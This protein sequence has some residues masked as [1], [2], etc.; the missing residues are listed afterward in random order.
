MRQIIFGFC[1]LGLA[2]C[3]GSKDAEDVPADAPKAVNPA[4]QWETPP[5]IGVMNLPEVNSFCTFWPEGHEFDF[6]DPESWQFVFVTVFDGTDT[7]PDNLDGYVQLAGQQ[8]KVELITAEASEM[9]EV[10]QYR[11]KDAPVAVLEV[12]MNKGDEGYEAISYTGRIKVTYPDG[13]K[14]IKFEGDCGV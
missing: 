12:V 6:N 13:V 8:R 5:E 3:G 11:T 1:A 7:S 9:G 14:P 10:R 4:E 2:A